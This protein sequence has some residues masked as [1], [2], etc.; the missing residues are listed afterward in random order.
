[1][2]PGRGG[3]CGSW[4]RRPGAR[5]RCCGGGCRRRPP[6]DPAKVTRLVAC[7]DDDRLGERERSSRELE[8]LGEAAAPLLRRALEDGATPAEARRRIE[9]ILERWR[10]PTP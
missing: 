6:P 1:M 10:G 8:A 4:S 9:Q 2:P 5:C 3:R 7:L